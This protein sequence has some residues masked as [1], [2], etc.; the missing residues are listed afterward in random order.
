MIFNSKGMA[1][2]LSSCIFCL[3]DRGRVFYEGPLVYGIWDGFPVSEGHALLIPH[4]H[5]ETWFDATVEEQQELMRGIEAAKQIIQAQYQP[6]GF[7]IGLNVGAAAGQ[8]VFHLHVHI[9]PRKKGDVEDPRGGVRHVIPQRANYLSDPLGQKATLLK[10]P[11]DQSL[12]RGENDPFLPH[13]LAHINLAHR[14]DFAVAFTMASGVLLIKDHLQDLLD[15]GGKIRFL[16]GDYFHVTEPHALL[17]LLDLTGSIDFRVFQTQN[18]SFHPKGYIFYNKEGGGVAVVGSS[19]LSKTALENGLEWNYRVITSKDRA[20]FNDVATAFDALFQHPATVPLNYEWVESYQQRRKPIPPQITGEIK[21]EQISPPDPNGIQLEAMQALEKTRQ[22]GNQAGLVVLA[23]GL[24][25]TWLSAFD[26]HRDSFQRI[27]FVAH[28]EEILLQ[29]CQTFRD[30]RPGARLGFYTGQHRDND[31][32]ILFASV[33]TLS[34][35]AHLRAFSPEDFDYIVIDEF[36]HASARTYRNLIDYFEP[37]F[38]LGLTATPE[39]TDGGNLLQLCQENL[40]YRCD[41][42]AGIQRD[43][44]CPFH[45]FGVPDNV[46]YDQIPWRSGRFNEKKLTEHVATEMRAQ[47]VLEQYQGKAGMRTLAFCCSTLHADYMKVYFATRGIRAAAVHSGENSDPRTASLKKLKQGDLD[48]IFSVDM[49]NEGLD[50]P[51]ID[52]VMMLR[53]TE[54]RLL[55]LQ[56]LGRG[57]RRSEGKEFLTVIDYIGNHKAFLI[58]YQAL[59]EVLVAFQPGTQFLRQNLN[60]IRSQQLELP[61]GC[62]ITYDLKEVLDIL[63]SLIPLPDRS[64]EL[65]I[66]YTDFLDRHN[67]RPTAMETFHEGYNPKSVSSE[68]GSWFHFLKKRD[69]LPDEQKVVLENERVVEFLRYIETTQMSRSYK[70]LV[71]LAM[72]NAGEF[73]GRMNIDDLVKGFVKLAGRSAKLRRD[74]SVSLDDQTA[75]KH[76]IEQNPVRAW[77]GG[78]G[79]GGVQYFKYEN[80][81]FQFTL[82]VP[83]EVREE[84]QELTRE[85]VDWRLAAYLSR[86]VDDPETQF[87][88]KVSNSGGRPILF[89]P[90]RKKQ[91]GIPEGW[92]DVIVDEER[93]QANF[94]KI[95]VNV[96]R[97]KGSRENALPGILRKWFGP[98]AGMRGTSHHVCFVFVEGAYRLEPVGNKPV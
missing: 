33:Q 18:N 58:K 76:L 57:L 20:G 15:R 19:N 4:R 68:H 13:L 91:S 6:D 39:R 87:V 95:A 55:W 82:E 96:F 53:P 24:G 43:L 17:R 28:R 90:D 80:G 54:S 22:Q 52:T 73:P 72:F 10:P 62:G 85:L 40:V 59:L 44:L 42:V 2:N 36:H 37:Q 31:A 21:E 46:E 49:F 56:Q 93:Y 11:H 12:I 27:L 7:N 3:P 71:I 78:R 9:I 61:P 94:V 16:T 23:T 51:S 69:D 81:V 89:L 26:S 34:R 29:A 70:M 50:V 97:L 35:E 14:V 1:L 67:R 92:Q 48:I 45:Y 30:I 64:E 47:N 86:S 84:F 79:T 63:D 5:V 32:E 98:D 65:R 88:C 74:I 8:T 83:E 25:K 66:F 38:L 77:T 41:L 75:L 60:R